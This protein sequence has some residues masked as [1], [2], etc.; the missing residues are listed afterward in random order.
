[1]AGLRL[2]PQQVEVVAERFRALA[3][4]AR[5]HLLIALRDGELAVSDLVEATGLGTA[6]VSKHL[7]QL[8]GAG[9]VTRRKEGL[10]VFYG[11]AGK[12]VSKLCDLMCGQLEAEA[13][14]KQ[15]LFASR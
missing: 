8:H 4:P 14:V 10:F 2:T 15:K 11:L 6:N 1:M 7:Q 5:L 9:Y 13:A 3:E 12:H